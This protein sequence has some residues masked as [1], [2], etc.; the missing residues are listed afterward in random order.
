VKNKRP[1]TK[2][3]EPLAKKRLKTNRAVIPL[4]NI[5][6]ATPGD[7]EG[8]LP[9]L[10]YSRFY[11]C[12]RE[13]K[14][15]KDEHFLAININRKGGNEEH[16]DEVFNPD[17]RIS[18]PV[19]LANI[20]GISI[21]SGMNPCEE[22]LKAYYDRFAL[23]N[24]I[25]H[26]RK[27]ID[28]RIE[29]HAKKQT[30][31]LKLPEVEDISVLEPEVEEENVLVVEA[32][33]KVD[34]VGN[35]EEDHKTP[36]QATR[37]VPEKLDEF[38]VDE[39]KSKAEEVERLKLNEKRKEEM[40]RK[41]R[42]RLQLLRK[43]ELAIKK[44]NL[45]EVAVEKLAA[46]IEKARARLAH[47]EQKLHDIATNYGQRLTYFQK[48]ME[49]VEAL[50]HFKNELMECMESSVEGNSK[51]VEMEVDEATDVNEISSADAV[52]AE[53]EAQ[54]AEM[55]ESEVKEQI[56]GTCSSSGDPEI[57]DKKSDDKCG[58]NQEVEESVDRA[59]VSEIK[60][61][62][63]WIS[64]LLKNPLEKFYASTPKNSICDKNVLEKVSLILLKYNSKYKSKIVL[65]NITYHGAEEHLNNLN[66]VIR[67]P[68]K[69]I[70]KTPSELLKDKSPYS[71]E[72]TLQFLAKTHQRQKVL[73]NIVDSCDMC[74]S[75]IKRMFMDKHL[76]LYCVKRQ[77]IC[78]YC[79]GS[80][81]FEKIAEHHENECPQIPVLCPLKCSHKYAR[82]L[83]EKHEM[84]CINVN[85]WCDFR[86]LGCE[87]NVKRKQLPRHMK[88]AA[89]DHVKLL[90]KQLMRLT[91]YLMERDLTLV[92]MLNPAT[93]AEKSIN[94]NEKAEGDV[95]DN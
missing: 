53:E 9:K 94:E 70:C 3:T 63:V 45:A 46:S 42:E 82:C 67:G 48:N 15:G 6:L 49:D 59:E 36:T 24:S 11:K 88:N 27:V 72:R 44:K 5:I 83:A 7:N 74:E 1:L 31:F 68:W 40:E 23:K 8:E 78:E 57:G 25:E 35:D 61:T 13:V 19:P 55:V 47:E 90:N 26:W 73:D 38:F 4:T 75:N 50:T 64:I 39:E 79:N 41:A 43:R 52:Y 21:L 86:H 18:I 51:H 65:K 29:M 34:T 33:D 69:N 71:L 14:V 28:K 54:K 2:T 84:T 12:N 76:R 58:V 37:V 20:E 89:I 30:E 16:Q 10:I 66:Q 85:V 32:E 80:F 60:E 95:V 92:D 56:D 91:G 22:L 81:V 77:E 17:D 93:P 62:P 87:A